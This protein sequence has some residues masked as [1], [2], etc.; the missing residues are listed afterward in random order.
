MNFLLI[1]LAL[2]IVGITALSVL[3]FVPLFDE[4]RI[5]IPSHLSE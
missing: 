4:R 1:L 5:Q 2:L 3:D